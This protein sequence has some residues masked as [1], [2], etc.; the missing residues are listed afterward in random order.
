MPLSGLQRGQ[1][2]L[3][4][5]G[6]DAFDQDRRKPRPVQVREACFG[7][8]VCIADPRIA[9]AILNP[10]ETP[11]VSATA[12]VECSE[13]G[14]V[15]PRPGHPL[16]R[17]RLPWFVSHGQ[18]RQPC[19]RVEHRSVAT[20]RCRPTGETTMRIDPRIL[21]LIQIG[22]IVAADQLAPL[23]EFGNLWLRL[24]GAALAVLGLGVSVAAKRQFQRAGT[25]V[26]TFKEPGE[27][28]TEGLYGVSRNPMYLGLV[29]GGIGT[30][31]ISGT[32]AGLILCAGFAAVVRFWYIAHEEQA[33][34][35]KFGGPYEAY[36]EEVW[37]WLGP[38]GGSGE[39]HSSHR[40]EGVG[41]NSPA[42][43]DAPR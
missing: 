5:R 16:Q 13:A 19:R 25:N 37:R 14:L 39:R 9:A 12:G 33:M 20:G 30:A 3:S 1:P 32:L 24:A 34:R 15:W 10:G 18:S 43:G 21:F 40:G 7:E 41:I 22:S 38:R 8:S 11:Q 17:R 27:L 6:G 42:G 36:C 31:L 4:P 29:L 2:L 28:V 35:R 26:Y 23:I